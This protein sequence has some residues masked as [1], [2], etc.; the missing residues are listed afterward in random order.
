MIIDAR[1]TGKYYEE[2]DGVISRNLVYDI[3]EHKWYKSPLSDDYLSPNTRKLKRLN[4][5]FLGLLLAVTFIIIIVL[6][7]CF[8]R[9]VKKNN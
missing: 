8:K 4:Y 5:F 7:V 6:V 9:R 3:N 1:D 2:V